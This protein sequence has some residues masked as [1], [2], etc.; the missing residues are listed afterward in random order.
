MHQPADPHRYEIRTVLPN[1]QRTCTPFDQ[2]GACDIGELAAFIRSQCPE[3]I[4]ILVVE[5]AHAA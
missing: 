2:D 1:G 5:V 3:P 4:R